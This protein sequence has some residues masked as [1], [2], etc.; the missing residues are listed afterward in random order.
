MRGGLPPSGEE[1]R[2]ITALHR[3]WLTLT[4][5]VYDASKHRGIAQLYAAD[6]RFTAYYD[7]AV[8]GCAR[9]LRT[10]SNAGLGSRSQKARRVLTRRASLFTGSAGRS[11]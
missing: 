6:E 5:T 10:R 4:G 1:G 7:G 8:P 2:E 11:C 9:F 3:R